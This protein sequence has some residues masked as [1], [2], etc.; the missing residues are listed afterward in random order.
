MIN[1]SNVKCYNCSVCNTMSGVGGAGLHSDGKLNLSPK[2]GKTNLLDF[3]DTIEAD[4]IINEI[5]NTLIR[6]GAP[7]QI[8]N[9]DS[10]K[11]NRIK[12]KAFKHDIDLLL[13]KQKH[14]GSDNLPNIIGSFL[15]EM[16]DNGLQMLL[17]NEVTDIIIKNGRYEAVKL[18][19]GKVIKSKF[20]VS[21]PGRVGA[22]W[23]KNQ[24][25]KHG[26]YSIIYIIPLVYQ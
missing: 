10:K 8:Y 21:C 26:A 13:I 16:K 18:K 1:H 20:L 25:L 7:K 12:E 3:V 2:H 11:E 6:H 5:D 17:G 4:S 23:M 19:D 15:D 14:L 24:A 22:G 9:T